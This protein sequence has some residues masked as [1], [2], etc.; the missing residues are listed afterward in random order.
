MSECVWQYT[1]APFKSADKERKKGFVLFF[2]LSPSIAKGFEA[3]FQFASLSPARFELR[4]V[5]RLS[6]F[7]SSRP[8]KK[9]KGSG[10]RVGGH[11]R[12]A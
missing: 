5:G 2:P 1:E 12:T 10:Q 4:V 7:A 8:A 6:Q 11:C 9:V 3:G